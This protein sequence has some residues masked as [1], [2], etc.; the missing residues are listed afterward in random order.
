MAAA[1]HNQLQL[2]RLFLNYRA[3]SPCVLCAP[4]TKA[5]GKQIS[6]T[7]C[8]CKGTP[9]FLF[10]GAGVRLFVLSRAGEWE[11]TLGGTG[12]AVR[13]GHRGG[14][15]RRRLRCKSCS[16]RTWRTS[17]ALLKQRQQKSRVVNHKSAPEKKTSQKAKRSRFYFFHFQKKSNTKQLR[18]NSTLVRL[19]HETSSRC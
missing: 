13:R 7:H 8:R 5:R 12:W 3:H 15:Q 18:Q 2:P 19:A 11:T 17:G 4:N 14:G 10:C 16:L 6:C 1:L 9:E